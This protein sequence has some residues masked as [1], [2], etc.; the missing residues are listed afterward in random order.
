[1]PLT[2]AIW[3]GAVR[4]GA[5]SKTDPL[6]R[7]PR[8]A[9]LAAMPRRTSTLCSC[10]LLGASPRGRRHTNGKTEGVA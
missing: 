5:P 10:R 6:P 1:M 4:R 8:A 9:R 3:S 2:V 7:T